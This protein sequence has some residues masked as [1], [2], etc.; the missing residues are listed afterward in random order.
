MIATVIVLAKAPVPGRVK[1]RCTPPCSPTEAAALAEAAIADTLE[2]VAGCAATRRIVALDGRPGS[3]LPDGFDVVDQ[4]SGSLGERIDRA[5]AAAGGPCVLIGM[6][7][8][9]V[10]VEQLDDALH[11]IG[12]GGHRPDLRCDAVVGSSTDGGFW[13]LGRSDPRRPA[14][15]CAAVAMSTASTG[16]DLLRRL[17]RLGLSCSLVDELTDVDDFA[18]ARTVAATVPT[19]RFA[20]SV[21]RIAQ[22]LGHVEA[23]A[24]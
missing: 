18:T 23:G 2:A 17:A 15:L 6:D 4:G 14:G 13:L 20:R 24:A 16:R 19:S 10:R 12:G 7:T 1:T 8:P 11:R 3:W 22:T 21:D 5:M 9:Q